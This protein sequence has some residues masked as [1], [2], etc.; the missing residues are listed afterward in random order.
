MSEAGVIT[1]ECIRGLVSWAV[2]NKTSPNHEFNPSLRISGG[3]PTQQVLAFSATT[4][5]R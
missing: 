3:Y 1:L 2:H 5:S 4:T